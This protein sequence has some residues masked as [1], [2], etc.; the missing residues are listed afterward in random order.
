MPLL[1]LGVVSQHFVIILI[2]LHQGYGIIY[3]TQA[4]R[5]SSSSY[6]AETLLL[7]TSVTLRERTE[8]TYVAWIKHYILFHNKQ[9]PKDM[10]VEEVQ[11]FLSHLDT[12]DR[13]AAST[14]NQALSALVFLYKVF[15]DQELESIDA[16]QAKRTRYLPTVLTKP[17][18]VVSPLD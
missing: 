6:S 16:L 4:T 13:V 3:P 15:L 17:E 1:S 2:F 18:V 9:H 11:S 12:T 7:V 5:P 14:Q 8:Q 10:G